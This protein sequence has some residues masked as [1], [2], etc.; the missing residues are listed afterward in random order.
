MPDTAIIAATNNGEIILLIAS[1]LLA[2]IAPWILA[3]VNSRKTKSNATKMFAWVF[4]FAI[5]LAIALM[6]IVHTNLASVCGYI[7]VCGG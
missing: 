4:T 3:L 2:L 1:M 6:V 5:L 7:K